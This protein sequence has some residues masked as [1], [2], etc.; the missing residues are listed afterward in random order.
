[1]LTHAIITCIGCLSNN[2]EI[3]LEF[4]LWRLEEVSAIY[5]RMVGNLLD[6][7][8][9]VSAIILKRNHTDWALWV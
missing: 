4:I 8:D 6:V 2:K 7:I 9:T 5:F 1:M 3:N